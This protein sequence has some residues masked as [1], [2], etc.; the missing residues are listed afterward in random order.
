M[1]NMSVHGKGHVSDPDG[2]MLTSVQRLFG[3]ASPMPKKAS[4]RDFCPE[5]G[6]QQTTSMCVGW[7]FRTGIYTRLKFKGITLSSEPSAQGIYSVGR[8]IDRP[9]PN[10]KLKDEGSM[11]N[12]VARGL[13]EWG[14]PLVEDWPFDPATV[15]DEPTLDQLESESRLKLLGYYGLRESDAELLKARFRQAIVNGFPVPLA[16]QVD[17]KFEDYQGKGLITFPTGRNFGGHYTCAIGYEDTASSGFVIEVA[18]SWGTSWGSGGYY[19]ADEKFFV[20][21]VDRYVMDVRKIVK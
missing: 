3:A 8:C 10:T 18:N 15:D 14:V 19:F 5:I 2:H 20:Q 13:T 12:Q 4:L 6:D 9:S 21:T 16:T 1:S 11:P 17:Q 7:G